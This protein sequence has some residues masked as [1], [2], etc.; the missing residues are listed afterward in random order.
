MV[1][2]TDVIVDYLRGQAAAVA[3]L[4]GSAD[5]LILSTITVAELYAGVR[6]GAERTALESFLTAF[7]IVSVDAT[8]AAKGGLFRRDFGKSHGVGLA[9]ALIAA[10]AELRSAKLVSLNAKHFP[11]LS[12]VEVP[13]QKP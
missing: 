2:D 5:E 11:M 8:I 3:Y 10:T 1:V 4:D 9:D 12:N 7:D 13:Y 6:E